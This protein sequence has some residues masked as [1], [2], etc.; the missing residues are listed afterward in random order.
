M[1]HL[2]RRPSLVTLLALTLAPASYGQEAAEAGTSRQRPQKASAKVER[3]AEGLV[4]HYDR[5]GDG[6]LS[7]EEWSLMQG[8]PESIDRDRDGRLVVSEVIDHVQRYS[9]Q[10]SL[11][12]L[13]PTREAK[14]AAATDEK[15]L[16]APV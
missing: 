15:P 13:P 5:D 10:R 14:P 6:V 11:R 9:R 8:R 2:V 4:R 1:M 7:V 16:P 3:C 12:L